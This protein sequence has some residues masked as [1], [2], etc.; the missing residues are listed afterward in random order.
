MF[1]V[2]AGPLASIQKT[3]AIKTRIP[4]FTK[5]LNQSRVLV[6]PNAI[7]VCFPLR[8]GRKFWKLRVHVVPGLGALDEDVGLGAEDARV[9]ERANAQA[10]DVRPGR[11]L[12]PERRAAI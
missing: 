6:V 8:I 4:I 5:Y 9:V 11:D 2:R 10:D 1:H 12:H 7:S 3:A